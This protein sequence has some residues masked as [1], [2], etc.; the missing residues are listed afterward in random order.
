MTHYV[1][2]AFYEPEETDWQKPRYVGMTRQWRSRISSHRGEARRGKSALPVHL[3]LA[4]LQ[5]AGKEPNVQE[6]CRFDGPFAQS[7]CIAA[8]KELIR[9][10]AQIGADLLNI[11]HNERFSMTA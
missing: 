3:W 2:Y 1:I 11:V 7:C 5:Q 6:L 10:F 4:S 8:E 9:W